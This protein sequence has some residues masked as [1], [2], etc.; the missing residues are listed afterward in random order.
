[1]DKTNGKINKKQHILVKIHPF[2]KPP[3]GYIGIYKYVLWETNTYNNVKREGKKVMG[4]RAKKK[5]P[6]NWFQISIPD[7]FHQ[8]CKWVQFLR[9]VLDYR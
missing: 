3:K 2:F 6:L 7:W 9:L 5:L 4:K 8:N 1:M